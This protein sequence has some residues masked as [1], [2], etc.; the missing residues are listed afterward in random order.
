M[1]FLTYDFSN[2]VLV[3]YPGGPP[4]DLQGPALPSGILGG[5]EYPS[6]RPPR[7]SRLIVLNRVSLLGPKVTETGRPRYRKTVPYWAT[8]LIDQYGTGHSPDYLRSP[9]GPEEN[10]TTDPQSTQHA[11][12]YGVRGVQDEG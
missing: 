6:H 9:V 8:S 1:V 12:T 11:T 5:D 3:S 4:H 2:S 10:S 7:V